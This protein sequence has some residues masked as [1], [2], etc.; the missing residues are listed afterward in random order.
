MPVTADRQNRTDADRRVSLYTALSD[1]IKVRHYSPKTLKSYTHRIRH[2][3]HFT[4]S[5]TPALLSDEDVKAFLTFLAVRQKVSS[6]GQNLAF[7][8]LLFFSD[9]FSEMSSVI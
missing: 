8:A 7:N 3:Q 4:R 9:T 6:S 1:E 2:F 5:R